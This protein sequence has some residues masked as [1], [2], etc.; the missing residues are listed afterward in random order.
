MTELTNAQV[1][2]ALGWAKEYR[3]REHPIDGQ[4]HDVWA[5]DG[6]DEKL[7]YRFTPTTNTDDAL[8]L[9]PDDYMT[10]LCIALECSCHFTNIKTGNDTTR[11]AD[12]LPLAICKALMELQHK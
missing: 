9:V 12:T 3:A 2:E 10:R 7:Y 11:Y 6:W 8:A 4:G 5:K 1:M